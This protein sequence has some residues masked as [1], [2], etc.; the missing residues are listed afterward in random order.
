[1]NYLVKSGLYL[2]F[3][4]QE[5]D[6]GRIIVTQG[7]RQVVLDDLSETDCSAMDRTT[8]RIILA[9]DSPENISRNRVEEVGEISVVPDSEESSS[10]EEDMD[11]SGLEE[12]R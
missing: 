3:Q 12:V 10:G 9:A 6:A 5:C 2:I 8:E 11:T 4:K 1:M 7:R